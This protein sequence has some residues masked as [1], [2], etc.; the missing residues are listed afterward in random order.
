MAG[1]LQRRRGTFPIPESA[2]NLPKVIP[3]PS[4]SNKDIHDLLLSR[5]T[6]IRLRW[7][8]WRSTRIPC[9]CTRHTGNTFQCVV[10]GINPPRRQSYWAVQR[11][12]FPCLKYHI[13][14]TV[15]P[16]RNEAT[17]R[18]SVSDSSGA[19]S[20]SN[21]LPCTTIT[22][23]SVTK[24]RSQ[25]FLLCS[26]QLYIFDLVRSWQ[27]ARKRPSTNRTGCWWIH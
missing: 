24:H 21:S 7:R 3:K 22:D 13:P 17:A 15:A 11:T 4:P 9:A 26:C 20:R 19:G 18:S 16:W 23:T 10:V 2:P 1:R 6:I 14:P 5:D 25:N 12:C 27:A 8:K